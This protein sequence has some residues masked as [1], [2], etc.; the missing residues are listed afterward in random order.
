MAYL[1]PTSI[2]SSGVAHM[3]TSLRFIGS[4]PLSIM[5]SKFSGECIVP[6]NLTLNTL[7]QLMGYGRLTERK[8]R[9]IVRH[10]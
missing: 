9:Y 3:C 10:K 5:D 1:L 7:K 8:I 4:S 6:K 2:A